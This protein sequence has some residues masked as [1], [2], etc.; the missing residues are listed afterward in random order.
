VAK[1]Q[2]QPLATTPPATKG[3]G[4][5]RLHAEQEFAAELEALAEV[6]TKQRPPR[7]RLSPWAVKTYLLGGT[8]ENGFEVTPKYIGNERLIEIAIATLATDRALL[9]FGLPGT[10]KSW[11]S[12]HLAAAISG[13]STLLIQGTAG[14]DES[15]LRYGWNYARL[16]AEGPSRNAL[17]ESPMLKA[18]EA[19]LICRVE[20]LTRISGEVQDTLITILSE[21]TLPVPELNTEVQ[22]A[23]G[24][25]VI[26]TANNRDKGVNELSSALVRRF[27]TVVLPVPE[28]LDDE[29]KIVNQ[30][31]EQLGRALELPAEKPALEEIR[32][33]VTIL[34]ELRNGV[35]EDGKT[36]VKSPSSTLSTAEAISVVTGGLAL[37]AFYGDGRLRAGDIISGLVGAIVKDPVQ[38]QLIWQ[39]YIQT[40]IK[41]RDDWKDLYRATRDFS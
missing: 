28:S 22:A 9:L 36:K 5:L 21:K 3:E 33:V 7:W 27:N 15:T 16:L 13:T 39:E 29:V 20:E 19:G 32:R 37:S 10:A 34:R 41:E 40:V 1:N 12:E 31:T 14:T 4:M 23:K 2:A 35:T 30:R 24:F 11:V 6:D 26:A 25:N 18:M 38:D 17:V 8:L